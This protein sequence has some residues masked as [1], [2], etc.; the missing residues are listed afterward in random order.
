MFGIQWPGSQNVERELLIMIK[1]LVLVLKGMAYGLTHVV[2]GLGGALVLII[3]GIYQPFVEAVGNVFVRL[4]RWRVYVPFLAALG[5]GTV[6][7]VLAFAKLVSQLMES[8]PAPT[9]LLFLGLLLGCIPSILRMHSDMR[10]TWGRG[11]A[12]VVG[13]A[14]VALLRGLQEGRLNALLGPNVAT[15]NNFAYN[16]T[17]STIAGAASVTPGLDGSYI[18]LLAGTY[19]PIMEALDGLSRLTIEW[20]ILIP[21]IIGSLVGIVGFSKLVDI[22][23][24]RRPSLTYYIVL[25]LVGGSVIGLWPRELN[26]QNL[27]VSLVCFAVGLAIAFYTSRPSEAAGATPGP[28]DAE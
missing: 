2:P 6:V 24:K 9:M 21:T 19:K 5:V 27:A 14:F 20:Q 4:D 3:L 28:T 16:L 25:G 7:A 13:L 8:Y 15:A 12:L 17:T 26:L 18:F 22:A 23:I 10:F 1:Y 11:L